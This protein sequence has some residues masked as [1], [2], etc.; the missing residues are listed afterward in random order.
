ME[1]HEKT[2]GNGL[3][4]VVTPRPSLHRVAV[5]LLVGVGSRYESESDNG[6][7]HFLE[8]MLYRGTARHPSA[9]AQ[10]HAFERIGGSLSATT[11]ADHTHLA[12]VAPPASLAESMEL[13]GE[14]VREPRLGEI[15]VERRIVREE[16]LDD[17][18]ETGRQI[19]P[20]N[21]VRIAMFGDHPLGY[22]ITGPIEALEKF[23]EPRLRAHLARYYVAANS[24]LS[25]AGA[26]DLEEAFSLAE[27]HFG[28]LP[29]GEM[30]APLPWSARKSIKRKHV[31]SPG[32]QTDLRLSFVTPGEK[33]PMGP[34]IELLMRTI[35]DGMST[36]LYRRLCD[37]GGMVYDCSA[38]WE[39]FVEVGALDL[40][41]EVSPER[42]TEVVQSCLEMVSEL[43]E[44][45]PTDEE[46]EKA[47]R[48]HRF[49]V[50]A[51]LDSA[52]ELEVTA[53]SAILF[54]RPRGFEAWKT[55]FDRIG[56]AEVQAA[57]REIF[58]RDA[59]HV[60]TVGTV[61]A[62]AKLELRKLLA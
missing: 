15:A 52:E 47:K 50:D 51:A 39:P 17:L 57:A 58:R 45:G 23:D 10:N 18:D 29:R 55:R 54:D 11:H 8:H 13:L 32:S 40:G 42:L 53:G 37:D 3:R 38:L 27:K 9:H 62:R 21:V 28:K 34:A 1:L 20:D 26:C 12:V 33:D 16:I 44:G 36:R 2:L 6:I 25:I 24:V 30:H 43:A 59:M 46:I 61:T 60:V 5:G 35:D 31:P 14:V 7:S 56:R 49:A 48:R 41:A 4:V 22:P 19:D